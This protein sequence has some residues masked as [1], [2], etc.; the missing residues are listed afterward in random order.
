MHLPNLTGIRALAALHVFLFHTTLTFPVVAA[1]PGGALLS[2]GVVGVTVFFILSGVVM[3]ISQLRTLH[4]TLADS[5]SFWMARAARILPTYYIAVIVMLVLWPL[6][7]AH[8]TPLQFGIVAFTSLTFLQTWIPGYT[9]LGHAQAWSLQVEVVF[10][11]LFPLLALWT[12][13]LNTRR[14][15]DLAGIVVTVSI[16]IAILHQ[17][18]LPWILPYAN[19]LFRLPEF[20]LGLILGRVFLAQP[21]PE[22]RWGLISISTWTVLLIVLLTLGRGV[23]TVP[24]LN[25]I[26]LPLISLGLY[27]LARAPLQSPISRLFGNRVMVHL[28]EISYAF[29][30]WHG[31]AILLVEK[32]LRLTGWTGV[33]VAL[34]LAV[35]FSELSHRFIERPIMR[36]YK[37]RSA[38]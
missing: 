15:L 26:L 18:G 1:L 11:A 3:A 19:P 35:S 31:A 22:A 17:F 29:Y 12:A 9:F 14:L 28:G 6:L 27:S 33:L 34:V 4:G 10:Y 30:L 13:K 23:E 21:T 32:A 2:S 5:R 37:A 7:L 38:R 16:C 24:T 25:P 20:L 8:P 36:R